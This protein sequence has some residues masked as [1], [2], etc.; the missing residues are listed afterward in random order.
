MAFDDSAWRVVADDNSTLTPFGSGPWGTGASGFPNPTP[1]R[2]MHI[3]DG[4]HTY[5]F[6]R[7]FVS[8][9]IGI[10][11]T[12][13]VSC[14]DTASVYLDGTL[15]FTTGPWTTAMSFSFSPSAFRT[16]VIA[17]SCTNTGGP[18]GLLVDVR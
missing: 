14:D 4:T 5:Y 7:T 13:T 6:R 17:I 16:H 2:W 15:R 11:K 9:A 18:G 10:P 8:D 3:A 1:A 12:V